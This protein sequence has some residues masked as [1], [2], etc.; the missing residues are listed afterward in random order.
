MHADH[1]LHR[2]YWLWELPASAYVDDCLH[3]VVTVIV[4]EGEGSCLIGNGQRELVVIHKTNLQ[5]TD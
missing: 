5:K 4:D 3:D 2:T 1:C